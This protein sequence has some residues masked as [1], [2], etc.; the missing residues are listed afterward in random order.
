MKLKSA[1]IVILL[2]MVAFSTLGILVE[3]QVGQAS[4]SSATQTSP[5]AGYDGSE[6]TSGGPM[7]TDVGNNTV[8]QNTG[9]TSDFSSQAQHFQVLTK[10]KNQFDIYWEHNASY[11]HV[12]VDTV[13]QGFVAIG[14]RTSLPPVALG[15]PVMDGASI[16]IGQAFPSNNTFLLR[17][18]YGI[19]GNHFP[20]SWLSK[21]ITVG[22]QNITVYG[23]EYVH[24]LVKQV[25][26]NGQIHTVMEFV[27]P[28][29]MPNPYN[30]TT[31]FQGYSPYVNLTIGSYAY[32]LV[33]SYTQADTSFT[34][35]YSN[36]T[37]IT[38]PMMMYHGDNRMVISKPVFIQNGATSYPQKWLSAPY[39]ILKNYPSTDIFTPIINN[40]QTIMQN[41]VANGGFTNA[42][43]PITGMFFF[44]AF[45]GGAS[46]YVII[47]A[48]KKH[49]NAISVLIPFVIIGVFVLTIIAFP[50]PIIIQPVT[51][52]PPN[53]GNPIC[54]QV[55]AQVILE[56]H[57]KPWNFNITIYQNADLNA[58][59]KN[60]WADPTQAYAGKENAL[61]MLNRSDYQPDTT[62]YGGLV[63]WNFTVYTNQIVHLILQAQDTEHGFTIIDNNGNT[64]NDL[65]TGKQIYLTLPQHNPQNVYFQAPSAPAVW[66]YRCIF[67]CG[68]GHFGME[69]NIIIANPPS[70]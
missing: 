8:F 58:S 12:L 27:N 60:N 9:S 13:S 31:P 15:A 1:L 61:N 25:T 50:L 35:N 68:A 57:L 38:A 20:D 30:I 24:G 63:I 34:V 70:T 39:I 7:I 49:W 69:G 67:Y 36:G 37:S 54:S 11:M 17:N 45:I 14:W 19:A 48:R 6:I 44:L 33:S 2:T 28:L 66:L 62:G 29:I 59:L 18:D 32:F 56:A 10:A 64:I 42:V 47:Y 23:Q 21:N 26:E 65:V 55:G 46:L 5:P 53:T 16:V 3:M 4:I 43:I 40:I 41:L 22:S 51:C 52:V